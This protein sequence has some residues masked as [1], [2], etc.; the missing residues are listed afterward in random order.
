VSQ[1]GN[2]G[3]KRGRRGIDGSYTK[4]TPTTVTSFVFIVLLR[5]RRSILILI[6]SSGGSNPSVS[7]PA[8][9]PKPI[10]DARGGISQG[11]PEP[12]TKADRSN[13]SGIAPNMERSKI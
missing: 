12:Q 13:F 11:Y 5:I 6:C 2:F 4:Q 10:G 8:D 9:F 3:G 1:F 7:G